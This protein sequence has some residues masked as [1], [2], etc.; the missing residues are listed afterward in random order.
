MVGKMVEDALEM[1]GKGLDRERRQEMVEM[2]LKMVEEVIG[3]GGKRWW[4]WG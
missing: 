3:K 1:V 2:G 4:K